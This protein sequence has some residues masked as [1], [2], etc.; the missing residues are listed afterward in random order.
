[1]RKP[2]PKWFK[3]QFEIAVPLKAQTQTAYK[4]KAEKWQN[5]MYD[6]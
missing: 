6:K 3:P 5:K 1:M 4:S 2:C